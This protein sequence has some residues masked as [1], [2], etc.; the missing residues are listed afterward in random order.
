[1]KRICFVVALMIGW[2]TISTASADVLYN[3]FGPGDTYN[4]SSGMTIGA[5]SNSEQG[6]GF[7]VVGGDFFFD[8]VVAPVGYVAGTNSVTM[9][10]YDS[11]GGL[12]GALL[13]QTTAAGLPSIGGSDPP[14]LFSFS[15]STVLNNGAD[16]FLVASNGLNGVDWHGWHFNSI[17]DTGGRPFR[18]NGGAWSDAGGSNGAFRVNGSAVPEPGSLSL[19]ALA[20]IGLLFQRRR[21]R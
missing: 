6:V 4:T 20:G 5:T 3:N 11:V 8:D 15:G 18:S 9:S 13:E 2:S 16:Y 21:N 12:P 10:L 17:G 19:L 1:M 7:T 14:T